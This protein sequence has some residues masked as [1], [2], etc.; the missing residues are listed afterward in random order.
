MGV[1]D[2]ALFFRGRRRRKRRK[3]KACF[4]HGRAR[5]VCLSRARATRGA[6]SSEL[7]P[8]RRERKAAEE[9]RRERNVREASETAFFFSF[10]IFDVDTVFSTS[11]K[12]SS[13]RKRRN[14]DYTSL[15]SPKT[16]VSKKTSRGPQ[17]APSLSPLTDRALQT[18]TASQPRPP[19]PAPQTLASPPPSPPPSRGGKRRRPQKG[20]LPM[21]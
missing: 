2:G 11:I 16:I 19:R 10:S 7:F 14:F 13:F 17:Q 12:T 18:T 5:A 4:R 15:Y 1:A 6:C 20:A 8:P 3:G 9:R 21:L